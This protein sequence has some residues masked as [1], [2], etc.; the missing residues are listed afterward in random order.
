MTTCIGAP[1]VGQR[2]AR[3]GEGGRGGGWAALG[4]AC[5]IRR[6]MVARGIAQ[7][8]WSKRMKSGS[9]SIFLDQ[10]GK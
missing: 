9:E 1:Q 2:A 8:A 5:T 6:R 7:L 3:G 4:C 10:G